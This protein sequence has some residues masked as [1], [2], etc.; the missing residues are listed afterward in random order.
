[1][2]SFGGADCDTDKY[3]VVAKV[4]ERLA[5]STEATQKFDMERFNLRKLSELKVST[6]C[7][8]KISNRFAALENFNDR[9]DIK[10]VWENIKQNIKTTAKGSLGLYIFKQHK[11]WFDE[12]SSRF[13]E[14]KSKLKYSG[15]R[16]QTKV[17]YII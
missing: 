4:M 17:M 6:Q 14:Q 10:R 3:L 12:E 2:R 1:M 9:E 5:L 11:S 16:M 7:Q 13:L 8:I 15:Y